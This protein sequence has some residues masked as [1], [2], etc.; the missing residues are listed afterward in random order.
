M[1]NSGHS[2][3]NIIQMPQ[4]NIPTNKQT[5]KQTNINISKKFQLCLKEQ[6]NNNNE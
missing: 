5:N 3:I 2:T 1:Y 6:K 4:K